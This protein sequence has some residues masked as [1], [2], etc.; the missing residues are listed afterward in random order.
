[1]SKAFTQTAERC[2]RDSHA[3][4]ASFGQIV[5]ALA[6]AGTES[7]YADYRKRLTN[8]YAEDG[9]THTVELHAP[10]LPIPSTFDAAALQA[11]IRG[12]QRGEVMYPE[13]MRLSMAA[14]CVGYIVWIAG[15]HVSYFGRRGE[16]HIEAFP[17]Q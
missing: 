3:G 14:G 5:A 16:V 6:Q 2:A 17:P 9:A 10:D 12:A 8:Y 1:M 13:F 7:Y 4:A 11:A 15:R